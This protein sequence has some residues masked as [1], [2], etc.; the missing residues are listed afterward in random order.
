MIFIKKGNKKSGKIL[1]RIFVIT[2]IILLAIFTV[3][4]VYTVN[5]IDFY[6]DEALFSAEQ[7]K[8]ATRF[9]YDKSGYCG[10]D[11]EKYDPVL[12]ATYGGGSEK[13]EWVSFDGVSE[14]LKNGFVVVEDHKFWSHNGVN[15]RRTVQAFLNYVFNRDASFG[16]STITQQ[17]I[18]NISG[19]NEKSVKRKLQELVRAYHIE[20]K[21]TKEEIFELYLNIIPM[22][23]NIY[24]VAAASKEYFGKDAAALTA[25]EA[26][27]LIGITN[28][29]TKY[30]PRRESDACLKKRNN[31][32]FA[33]YESCVI[34]KEEYETSINAPLGILPKNN[35]DEDVNSWFIESVCDELCED[36]MNK[37]GYSYS[38]ARILISNGGLSVYTTLDPRVQTILEKYFEDESNFPNQVDCGLQFSMVVADSENGALRGVIGGVG[39]KRANRI[40]NHATSVK[41]PGS[42]LK[43]LAL[44]AP[45]INE[46]KI[47]W[48]SV[49]DDVPVSFKEKSD[50]TFVEFPKNSP[51]VYEGLTTVADALARSKNTVAVRLYEML[52]AEKI[53]DNLYKNFRFDTL[54][55]KEKNKSGRIVTDLDVAPLAL[56]QLSR[57]VTLRKLTEAYTVFPG[58][59][60]LNNSR[61]Y[62]FLLDAKNKCILKKT[63]ESKRIFSKESARVM[64]QMLSGVVE[65]G[66]ASRITLGN[67]VDVA[68]KTGTS[69]G[70]KDK[71]FIGYTP[72]F[73]AGIW[74]GWSDYSQSVSNFSKNHLNIWDEVM[75]EIHTDIDFTEENE[76]RFS[77]HGLEYLPYCKD[78]GKLY[79]P[80]CSNDMRGSRLE[81]GFFIRGSEPIEMCDVHIL[82]E[83]SGAENGYNKKTTALLLLPERKFPKDIQVMDEEYSYTN[84]NKK[85]ELE[86]D[87]KTE[88]RQKDLSKRESKFFK[89]RKKS[90]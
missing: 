21:Y 27:T 38:A 49:F 1:F 73:T 39:K 56:G 35:A 12:F 70:S 81:Y 52:G 22:G 60:K 61:S 82:C 63:N 30:N 84:H 20:K 31:V 42:V 89:R 87:I 90:H 59:G 77:L 15:L 2:V 5:S 28:A 79:S 6:S 14:Y 54:V 26:A 68:G 41:T 65:D 85:S 71:L 45:L 48:S 64:N 32:L 74:C 37:C 58:E 66:T 62:L 11:I 83:N 44:Y 50:G 34:S 47:T 24:G 40:L 51:A 76:R 13:R 33:M 57:G 7:N 3:M 43:P 36:L 80:I 17:V 46:G 4:C 18:K 9:F 55:K 69:G 16:A 10:D 8:N 19:D 86:F 25:A 67:L 88:H 78:S 75:R 72:Y 53:Y 23:E 29:P